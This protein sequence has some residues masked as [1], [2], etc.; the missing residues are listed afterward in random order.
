MKD[1]L[2]PLSMGHTA[3]HAKEDPGNHTHSAD[4]VFLGVTGLHRGIT[5]NRA[6]IWHR[7]VTSKCCGRARRVI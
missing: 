6:G 1:E 7:D 2:G 3:H 5:A 4:G